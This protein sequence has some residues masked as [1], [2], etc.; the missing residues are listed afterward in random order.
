VLLI[1]GFLLDSS[2]FDRQVE[3]L[4]GQYRFRHPGPARGRPLLA[5]GG[6][7]LP[8]DPVPAAGHSSSMEQPGPVTAA[9]QRFL[10]SAAPG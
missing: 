5:P 2:M 3:A 4:A 1:H 8:E 6:E 9:I 7:L 10:S